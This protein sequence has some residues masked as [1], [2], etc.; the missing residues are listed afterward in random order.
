MV[1]AGVKQSPLWVCQMEGHGRQPTGQ[2]LRLF[3]GAQTRESLQMPPPTLTQPNHMLGV[4]RG[5]WG[6]L[7]SESWARIVPL[8]S[9]KRDSGQ[10]GP[11]WSCSQA[12]LAQNTCSVVSDSREWARLLMSSVQ[13]WQL[14]A[15]E[16]PHE[17]PCHLAFFGGQYVK[18][19][20]FIPC[21]F[22]IS[23]VGLDFSFF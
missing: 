1:G 21:G 13:A 11:S 18:H 16:Q 17:L 9:A 3:P 22:S 7:G 10:V 5:I 20:C 2:A 15:G 6:N 19:G 12:R 14:A 23:T 4:A 8:R